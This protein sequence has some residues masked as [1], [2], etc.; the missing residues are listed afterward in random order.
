MSECFIKI[1]VKT[2]N[3][4][5]TEERVF[6]SADEAIRFLGAYKIVMAIT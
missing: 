5:H 3:P 6:K 4:H 1:S 2:Y